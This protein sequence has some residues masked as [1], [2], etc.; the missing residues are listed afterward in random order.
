M[1]VAPAS[2]NIKRSLDEESG[3]TESVVFIHLLP[4]PAA[5]DPQPTP[6][7]CGCL[8]AKP[9][10]DVREKILHTNDVILYTQGQVNKRGKVVYQHNGE[11][12]P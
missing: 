10:R 1:N 9:N 7:K 8:C 3:A 6:L 5:F 11:P 12:T 2:E 4:S